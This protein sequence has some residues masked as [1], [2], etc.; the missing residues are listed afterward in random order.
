MS[1]V[2]IGA[3]ALGGRAIYTSVTGFI[4]AKEQKIDDKIIAVEKQMASIDEAVAKIT[5][6]N[7]RVALS[8]KEIQ[9]RQEVRTKSQSELLT[10]AVGKVA[11]AVVSIAISKDVPQLEVV[12]QNPFGNDPF[13]KDF[14][15]QVPVYRQKGVARQKVGGGSGFLITSN[16]YILTNKHVVADENAS[17]S[18]LLANGTQKDARVVYKDPTN[19]M[20]IAKIEGVGFKT[21]TLGDSRTVKLGESVIAIGN[22][23]GEYNNSV[24]VGIISGLNRSLQAQDGA[25]NAETLSGV[26]QTDAAINPGNSGGPLVNMRGEAIGINVA[27]VLGSSNVSFSL[28]INSIKSTLKKELGI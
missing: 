19:D 17:Y 28:P 3:A 13:F 6:E 10:E 14:N 22:A 7:T 20:A 27:T 1:L 23:L 12:Y 26:F 21:V 25:G 24:S 16:G 9:N 5:G 11:P 8:L 18:V 15:I 2:I 4:A